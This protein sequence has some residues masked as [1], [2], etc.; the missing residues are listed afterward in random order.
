V[1]KRKQGD[2]E[3]P[4]LFEDLMGGDDN[5]DPI[6][7]EFDP[8]KKEP[9][10]RDAD[11]NHL[12]ADDES[13]ELEIVTEIEKEN[14]AE[15]EPA[16]GAFDDPDLAGIDEDLLKVA[17]ADKELALRL[18]E[19]RDERASLIAEREQGHLQQRQQQLQAV[20]KRLGELPD[21]IKDI[22]SRLKKAKE[23]G[24]TDGEIELSDQLYRLR[25]E[26]QL[27]QL[28]KP[29]IEQALAA[30]PERQEQPKRQ[31]RQAEAMQPRNQLAAQYKQRNPWIG[32]PRYRGQTERLAQIDETMAAEGLDPSKPEYFR[33]LDRRM[34]VHYPDL[35]RQ[36]AAAR[37]TT[38]RSPVAPAPR[39]VVASQSNTSNRVRLT[40]EDVE[41]MQRFKIDPKDKEA[42]ARYAREKLAIER[43]EKARG[44]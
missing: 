18:Q 28:A 23:E 35:P 44:R 39:G 36:G 33:E 34:R 2:E 21:E 32:N 29:Q 9:I 22:K 41:N 7:V 31:Q 1:A 4:I 15:E 16:E 24:D 37:P 17:K 3:D 11:E 6:D 5:T 43:A 40:R 26:E 14:K 12:V 19:E 30:G 38:G 8:I 42:V 25:Q 13:E 20:N 10:V 27:A